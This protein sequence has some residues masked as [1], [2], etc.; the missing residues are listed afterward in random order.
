MIKR[1]T[2][3]EAISRPEAIEIAKGMF[4]ASYMRP[5]EEEQVTSMLARLITGPGHFITALSS[6]GKVQ[7]IASF[8]IGP[9]NFMQYQVAYEHFVYV[10]P[11]YRKSTV[12]LRLIK[13]MEKWAKELGAAELM[14]GS[15]NKDAQQAEAYG[16]MLQKIGFSNAVKSY[17]KQLV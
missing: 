16:N 15:A 13:E 5:Y 11:E 10:F 8:Y 6:D 3:I 1:E 7:G 12:L 17:R 9:D 14:I 4:E 2:A